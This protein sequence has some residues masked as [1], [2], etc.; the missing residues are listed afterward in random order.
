L[1]L[2]GPKIGL[3][4]TAQLD[5]HGIS[6]PVLGG[7]VR[8]PHPAFADAVF[9]HVGLLDALEADADAALEHFGV[10]EGAAGIVGKAVGRRIVQ[11]RVVH[12][13][14]SCHESSE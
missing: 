1:L 11:R 12:E 3:D 7:R 13:Q 2:V 5:G 10:V 9:L 4:R 8:H 14:R 6:P